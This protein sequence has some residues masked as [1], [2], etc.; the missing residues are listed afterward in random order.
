[1]KLRNVR[2]GSVCN[3]MRSLPLVPLAGAR[4]F[5]PAAPCVVIKKARFNLTDQHT[6]KDSMSAG[7]PRVTPSLARFGNRYPKRLIIANAVARQCTTAMA[8]VVDA[9]LGNERRLRS[10]GVAKLRDDCRTPDPLVWWGPRSDIRLLSPLLWVC[11]DFAHG[12]QYD[13]QLC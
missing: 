12:L 8:S 10:D 1:M 6:D 5:V 2:G 11:T 13:C 9:L 3:N 7:C 4:Y